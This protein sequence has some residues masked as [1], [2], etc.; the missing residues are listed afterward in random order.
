MSCNNFG[1]EKAS[2]HGRLL[3]ARNRIFSVGDVGVELG[4]RS[5]TLVGELVNAIIYIRIKD[6]AS[7]FP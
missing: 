1:N 2:G 4:L 6:Y 3:A 7:K 5:A